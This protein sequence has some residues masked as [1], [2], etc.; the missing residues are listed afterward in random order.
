MSCF[1]S[2]ESRSLPSRTAKQGHWPSEFTAAEKC[3][4][5]GSAWLQSRA[6]C[7]PHWAAS[8]ATEGTDGSAV[9]Q[10]TQSRSIHLPRR[11]A[12][13]NTQICHQQM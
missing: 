11:D 5:M 4:A 6:M 3:H 10:Y 13:E 8:M 9:P 2:Q 1:L 7:I 12:K